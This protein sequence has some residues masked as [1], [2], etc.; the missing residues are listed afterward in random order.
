MLIPT[1]K[2]Y[3]TS[4]WLCVMTWAGSQTN[5]YSLRAIPSVAPDI[6]QPICTIR[7]ISQAIKLLGSRS[8]R[9]AISPGMTR[10]RPLAAPAPEVSCA[11]SVLLAAIRCNGWRV[12]RG[13]R[14]FA[15]RGGNPGI[16]ADAGHHA[17]AIAGFGAG[18]DIGTALGN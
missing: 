17:G 14:C 9:A 4:Y 16:A 5:G 12:K 10:V 15:C 6:A 3:R 8:T 7:Q 11:I 1:C 13:V 18:K 2:A